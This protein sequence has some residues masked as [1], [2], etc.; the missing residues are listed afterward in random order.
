[1][2]SLTPLL[3]IENIAKTVCFGVCRLC[4]L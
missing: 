3:V 4:N 1:M 2:I